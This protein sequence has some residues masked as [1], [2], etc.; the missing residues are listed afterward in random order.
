MKRTEGE[1]GGYHGY[2]GRRATSSFSRSR[3]PAE[4]NALYDQMKELTLSYSSK[5]LIQTKKTL[6]TA[7]QFGPNSACSAINPG[8]L[9][10]NNEF[11]LLCRSEPDETV[12][13][14]DFLA[15][16]AQPLWCTLREDLTLKDNFFL[17]YA[18]LPV[19]S[20][21]EDWRLFE[22]QGN[23]YANHSIY[24]LL[25]R[26]Q[27]MVRSRPGI[28]E[29]DL[30]NKTLNL[31]WMLEP[32]FEP[33]YEEKNWSFFVHEERLMCLYS[34]QPY[35]ILEID[36]ERGTTQKILEAELDYQWYDKGK[37]IGNSTNFVS[38]DDDRYI[39]FVHDF[40]DPKYDQ[41]NRTYM[42][43][44]ISIDKKTL[45]P[46]NI[47]PQPLVMGGEESG[48]HPGVHYTSALVNREDGLYAFYGQG[49]SHTGVVVFNKDC[50][51][52]LFDRY[53]LTLSNNTIIS[54]CKNFSTSCLVV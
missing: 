38:W 54:E 2:H 35:I 7:G 6:V 51:N 1:F 21:P 52:E 48:R 53:Q 14:G 17:S 9:Y 12:W 22:Y 46:T 3:S 20:R 27:W 47:I 45:L 28:S 26:Q 24:M 5:N 44:G 19:R 23:L 8:V 40:L 39:L 30:H 18:D 37:F 10:R 11:H 43:Y 34:F 32:P 13:H 42:Q 50:L 4:E 36:L 15:Y 41:R 33:T 49:D 29:I 16:Q 25:D 31:C